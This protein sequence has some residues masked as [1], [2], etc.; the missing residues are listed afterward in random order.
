V[1]T[2]AFLADRWPRLLPFLRAC[3]G[4]YVGK[5]ESC[6]RFLGAV[7]WI[8]H[9]GAQW[10]ALPAAYGKWNTVYKRFLR[11]CENGVW[12]QMQEACATDPDLEHLLLDS[13]IVRAHPCAAGAPHKRGAKRH[14][15]WVEAGA[16]SAARSI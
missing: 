15:R 5:E 1:I 8:A 7:L 11:W 13:T 10:R 2:E 6:L 16:A 14:K 12:K 4:I 3:P 9:T